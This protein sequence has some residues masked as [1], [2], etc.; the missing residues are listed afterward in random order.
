MRLTA[1]WLRGLSRAGGSTMKN[2]GNG[3][4][5]GLAFRSA[6]IGGSGMAALLAFA[7]AAP[8]YA[9]E[10]THRF[11]IPAQSLGSAL[12]AFAKASHSQ[13]TFEDDAVKGKRAAA[14]KGTYSARV[15]LEQLLEGTGLTADIGRSGLFIVRL[16]SSRKV[17]VGNG[18][19]NEEDVAIVVTGSRIERA[20]F[21]APTPTTV[22]G[23]TE[24]LQAGR[25][26]IASVLIDLP[27][28]RNTTSP[29]TT[30]TVISSGQASADLRGLGASRTL[31]LVN[32]RRLVN[33]DLQSI[34]FSLI[35][36]I[37]VVTGGASAAY[38]SDAVSG[39]VNIILDD[40]QKGLEVGTR[41]GISDRGDNAS[42]LF[43]GSFGTD[44]AGDRGHFMIGADYLISEG[45]QPATKRKIA[46]SGFFPV[47]GSNPLRQVPVTDL[48]EALRSEGGLIRNGPLAGFTFDPDG[49]VRPFQFGIRDSRSTNMIG[50]EGY[51]VNQVRSLSTPLDRVSVFARAS[52]DVAPSLKIW[53]DGSYNTVSSNRVFFDDPSIQQLVF[54]KSNPFLSADVRARQGT[55]G[56]FQIGRVPTDFA[57]NRFISDRE[58]FQVSVGFDGSFG[59]GKWRYD[60]YYSH[61][62]NASQLRITDLVLDEPFN[63]AIDAVANPAGGA[64]ICRI[65]LTNPTTPCRA[66]NLFGSGRGDPAAIDYVT[67]DWMSADKRTLDVAGVNFNGEPF[68]LWGKPVSFAA[69]A[70]Y[71][72]E[73]YEADYDANALKNA[74]KLLNGI[75][76]PGI[77]IDVKEAFAE[78]AVP[79]LVGIPAFQELVFN[80]AVRVSDYSAAGSITSWKLGLTNQVFDGLTL[81]GTRSRDIRAGSLLEL[82]GTRSTFSTTVVD[83]LPNTPL[84]N[85]RITVFTG[86][87]PNLQPEIADTL[88]VGAVVSPT[89][90]PG[91]ALSVD[92]YDI[93]IADA[94]TSLNGQ[95]IVN[96]C[97]LS[98]N[99]PA[100]AQIVRDSAGVISSI[101][102]SLINAALFKSNGVDIEATYYT[103]LSRLS[104]GL[105]GSIRLRAL[106][107]YVDK[108]TVDNGISVI[109]AAGVNSNSGFSTPRWRGTATL[110]YN[111]SSVGVDL[112]ARYIG[113]GRYVESDE[114]SIANNRIPAYTYVDLTLRTHVRTPGGRRFTL[115]GSVSNLFDRDPPIGAGF[116]F[117][118]PIGRSLTIGADIKF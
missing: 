112:R 4:R 29:T 27:V 71:R 55:Q 54:Q 57:L 70:E 43:K 68:T 86:S 74:F 2:S 84:A 19:A 117:Y 33:N 92:Y 46:T 108:Q 50:G 99:Q 25:N 45:I 101:D 98:G 5:K 11:D 17:S 9:Q 62:E 109:E 85:P 37:D 111:S 95:S 34:P 72:K 26:D 83:R 41:V 107:N 87:N 81:R 94:I 79:V 61:G 23:E 77:S 10:Q 115:Y 59:N 100:C 32:N 31:V 97:Y 7:Q 58:T 91:F 13:V 49:S 64:P 21:N 96:A 104:A 35:D 14:L 65:A 42:Y 76:I 82:F 16:S 22:I 113:A 52:F 12:R 24:L 63:N 3:L 36:R 75:A 93:K 69:G 118:S 105:P 106:V 44:F 103:R 8:V 102:A 80:G 47:A 56:T 40:N 114:T 38:G 73:S 20:G 110:S 88:T 53:V 30:N 18:P 60:G 89:F 90:L 1:L 48:R 116:S 28:F 6:T 51:N 66:L 67:A 15:A 39:V 78:V